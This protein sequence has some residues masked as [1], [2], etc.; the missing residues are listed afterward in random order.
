[1]DGAKQGFSIPPCQSCR[2][3]SYPLPQKS[4]QIRNPMLK[5]TVFS[6]LL[7]T[8]KQIGIYARG[9]V[10]ILKGLGSTLSIILSITSSDKFMPDSASVATTICF[11]FT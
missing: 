1:M 3:A 4:E 10:V 9:K 8:E 2:H 6:L 11:T 7:E 5:L